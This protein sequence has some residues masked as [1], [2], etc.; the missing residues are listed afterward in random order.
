M[1]RIIL[2]LALL[3]YSAASIAQ[4]PFQPTSIL[5]AEFDSIGNTFYD[6]QTYATIQNRICVYD[7]GTIG[8]TYTFGFDYPNFS[9]DRGT[10]YNYFDGSAWEPFPTERIESQRTGWNSYAPLGENG[11]II[12]AHLSGAVDDGLLFNKRILKGTGAW[13]ESLYH[14]PQGH[15]DVL[16]P[17]MVTGGENNNSVYLLSL[18]KPYQNGG[19]T[20][21]GL[22]GAL[23][24]SRS[25]DGGETWDI[26]NQIL[27][28]MDSSEYTGFTRDSYTLAEPKDN[29][30][31][32]VAGSFQHDL[33]LMKST[34]YGQTF[35]KTII[36]DHPYD[37]MSPTFY[38]DTFYCVDGS[39][40]IA[41]DIN[42]MAH[43]VFGI[44]RTYY[45]LDDW[46][47]FK[48]TDGVGYWNESMPAYSS[49][50][51]A[52]DPSCG[53]ESELTIDETLIGW[54]KDLNE[55]GTIDWVD[56]PGHPLGY[57]FSLGI[58]SMVQLVADNQNRLFLVYSSFTETYHNGAMNYR[59][60]FIRSSLNNG[61]TWGQFYHYD[62]TPYSI[63]NEY[64]FP[65]VASYSDDYLYM[66]YMI[67][68]EPGIYWQGSSGPYGENF[69]CFAKVSKD[70]I[71]GINQSKQS[72]AEFEVSQN[73]PNPFS[74]STT[75]KVNLRKP[76]DIKLEVFNLFGQ[77]VYE[78]NLQNAKP[79]LNTFSINAE[80]LVP[81]VYFYTVTSPE[82]SVTRKMIL[83]N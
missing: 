19:S 65:S 47:F 67:D 45:N 44:M 24:Y 48:T 76:S 75:I 20:Y 58:S 27:P 2:F 64:V 71:V 40:D 61:Q 37:L 28:G 30:V 29:I 63:F 33:I 5:N 21:Q 50:A 55:N 36:W 23:V 32:F 3:S 17:S 57:Y 69:I 82:F 15:E 25:T 14:G 12:I 74:K 62:E 26:F 77:K 35:E 4:L 46:K 10:G 66:T 51:N 22:D 8:A 18:T 43:V 83:D 38:T 54:T 81:G 56:I 6:R 39:I 73:F 7:D 16:F 68:N 11:E 59:R 60:L 13:T 49:N 9:S 80:S 70:E 79:G 42:G 53:P 34:D 41:L 31:A 52:L 78:T 1:K 72:T